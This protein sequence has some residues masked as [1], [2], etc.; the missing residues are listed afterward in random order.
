[1]RH[2]FYIMAAILAATALYGQSEIL[3]HYDSGQADKSWTFGLDG[4]YFTTRFTPPEEVWLAKARFYIADTS[5]GGTFDFSIYRAG[6]NEP[7]GALVNK[8]PMR[9]QRLGWNEIDLTSF[10]IQTAKDFYLSIEYDFKSELAMGA[11][12]SEPIEGRSFDSDC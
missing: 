6:D 7:A 3:L 5:N 1:M 11:D 8:V 10:Q 4:W 12:T 9:V 2:V